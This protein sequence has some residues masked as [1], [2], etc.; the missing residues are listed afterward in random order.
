MSF[1]REWFGLITDLHHGGC[2]G[3]DEQIHDYAKGHALIVVHPPENAAWIMDASKWRGETALP[4]KPYLERNKD[5]VDACD[6]LLV[7]PYEREEQERGG[8]WST[9]RYAKRQGVPVLIF[10]P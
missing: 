3:V 2:A 5:I 8:T 9:Y 1:L 7:V 10:W 6:L 4:S